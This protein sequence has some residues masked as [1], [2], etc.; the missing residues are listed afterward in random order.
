MRDRTHDTNKD[1][2][3]HIKYEEEV[4]IYHVA[5]IVVDSDVL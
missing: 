3:K 1:I 5:V 4:H 2:T